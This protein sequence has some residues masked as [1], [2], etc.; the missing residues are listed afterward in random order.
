MIVL[1]AMLNFTT[2]AGS[3]NPVAMAI[4]GGK[5]VAVGSNSQVRALAQGHTECWS[6]AQRPVCIRSR[7]QFTTADKSSP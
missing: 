6:P 4:A 2:L 5:I 3:D 7:A 1:L